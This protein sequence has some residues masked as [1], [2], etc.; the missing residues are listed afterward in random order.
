MSQTICREHLTCDGPGCELLGPTKRCSKCHCSFY[1]SVE[2]QKR[3]W[4]QEHKA[5]CRDIGWFRE[6]NVARISGESKGSVVSNDEEEAPNV[7][8]PARPTAVGDTSSCLICLEEPIVDPYT[9]PG[10][11]HAFCF[12]CLQQWQGFTKNEGWSDV[13]RDDGRIVRSGPAVTCPAC[14]AAAP[15]I[16][17]SI[18]EKAFQLSRQANRQSLCESEQKELREDAM[19]ELNKIIASK[20]ASTG[21]SAMLA[22][23]EILLALERPE[24]AVTLL[25][26]VVAF[27]EQGEET[28][29]KADALA[30]RAKE[31][32]LAG[33][34]D[35]ADRLYNEAMALLQA[36]GRRLSIDQSFD[37]YIF[38]AE[39]LEATENWSGAKD[40]YI[41]KIFKKV[42]DDPTVASPIQQR[43]MF[44]GLS[45][46][47]YHLTEYDKAIDAGSAAIEMNRHFPQV[48]KYVALA[49]KASGDL[50]EARKTMARAVC[51]ET[52]WDE[53]N[54]REVMELYQQLMDE[55]N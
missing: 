18:L 26:D 45:R 9:I 25:E 51:Y 17:Q 16:E 48:H 53:E 54:K 4:R 19:L 28:T 38:Y 46:C 31:A 50:D 34:D 44:M 20:D 14:R 3:H 21:I 13:T 23:A 47:C 5:D 10:C 22:S 41:E 6:Q 7:T 8:E 1:C 30:D 15:D 40:A 11:G 36:G 32:E 27:H 2:C 42:M 39:C 29:I 49:Q 52:P 43:K 35:E 37:M 12:K 55:E 33:R 24:E